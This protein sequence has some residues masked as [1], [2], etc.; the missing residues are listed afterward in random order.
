[1]ILNYT[2]FVLYVKNIEHQT[3]VSFLLLT[4]IYQFDRPKYIY[5][6]IATQPKKN[7]NFN[8]ILS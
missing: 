2:I 3:L 5:N 4:S 8:M 7:Q 6:Y 1:M